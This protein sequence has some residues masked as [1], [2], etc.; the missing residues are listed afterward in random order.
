MAFSFWRPQIVGR[1]WILRSCA[2]VAS[3]TRCMSTIPQRKRSNSLFGSENLDDLS[4]PC[5]ALAGRPMSDV[6]WVLN[7]AAR[8]TARA[9]RDMIEEADLSEALGRLLVAEH[10][11]I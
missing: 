11:R 3:T 10:N 7:E 2:K 9:K 4:A 8:L 6:A 5:E 1:P